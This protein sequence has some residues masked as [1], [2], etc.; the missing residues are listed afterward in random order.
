MWREVCSSDALFTA[1]R[2]RQM[3]GEQRQDFYTFSIT[4][5][6]DFD[7]NYFTEV[8]KRVPGLNDV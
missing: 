3:A 7:G 2:R 8:K 6:S 4:F 5:S 1:Q